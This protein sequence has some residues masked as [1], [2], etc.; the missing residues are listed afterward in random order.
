MKEFKGFRKGV[1]LGGWFSQ[2]DYSDDTLKNFITGQDIE[3]VAGWGAD[4][5]RIPVD[6]NVLENESGGYSEYG[7]GLVENAVRRCIDNGLNVVLD[8]HKTAG[9]SFDQGERE[10]G[11]FSSTE[12]Q[13]RF[14]MLWETIAKHFASFTPNI[15]FE[16]LNEVTDKEYMTVWSRISGECVKRIR[17]YAPDTVILL[18]GYWNN[19]VQA[20]PDLPAPFDDKIVYNFHCSDPLEFTHQG[21]YWIYDESF[22]KNKRVSFEESGVSAAYF[23]ELFAPAVKYAENNNTVLYCGEYGVINNADAED[24]VKWFKAINEVFEKHNIGRAVWSCKKMDFGLTD[25]HLSGV[26]DE[27]IKY[28]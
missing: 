15:A 3:R 26:I 22:D 21:A 4:H 19:S 18:G 2:C 25:E 11:F 24:T 5:V 1:D 8:L 9:F 13:E 17:K 20:V 6:Y 12:L 14:Y 27:L 10:T 23:E 16:L 28:L 7:F